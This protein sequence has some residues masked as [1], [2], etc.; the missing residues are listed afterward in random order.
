MRKLTLL[1]IVGLLATGG[2]AMAAQEGGAQ[3]V[4]QQPPQ[5]ADHPK[6]VEASNGAPVTSNG[7]I[8]YGVGMIEST[9]PG[10][11]DGQG[12]LDPLGGAG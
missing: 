8:Q 10:A 5:S 11:S 3:Q 4:A 7:G 9:T 6:G 2:A 12:A 1:A